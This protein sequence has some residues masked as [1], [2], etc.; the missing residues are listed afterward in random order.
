VTL[1]AGSDLYIDVGGPR[2]TAAKHMLFAYA[3]GGLQ[4][5]AVLQST[6]INAARLIGDSRLGV[7]KAG[8]YAD[9]VA[10]DGD[11]LADLAAIERVR[12]V[13]RGGSVVWYP[14]LSSSPRER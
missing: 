9:L 8:A 1:A 13:M 10:V 4:P 2:G 5:A 7:V 12:F 14:P 3:K 11:P 6:T